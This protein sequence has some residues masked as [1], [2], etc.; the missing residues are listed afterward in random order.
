[1]KSSDRKISIRY[2]DQEYCGTY[3]CISGMITV[4][5]MYGTS[6]VHGSTIARAQETLREIVLG[7][8]TGAK[9]E[10]KKLMK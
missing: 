10:H 7:F 8:V 4:T 2:E 5:S 9:Q 3:S 1:M 6:V